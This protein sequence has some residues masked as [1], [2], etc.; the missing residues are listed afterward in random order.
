MIA[1]SNPPLP[2]L[3]PAESRRIGITASC[4]DCDKL[5]KVLG[6]GQVFVDPQGVR[7]QLMHNGVR[8]VEDGYCGPWMTEL[9]HQLQGHHE[10]QEELAFQA[11]LEHLPA[12]ATMLE[13][14]SF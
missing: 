11:L 14:G 10:P 7:Y 5:P 1:V 3:S 8:V 6:A 13:L 9:I 4:R 12:G 2:Q